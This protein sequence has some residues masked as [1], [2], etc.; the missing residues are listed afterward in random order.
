M[1]MKKIKTDIWIDSN[2]QGVNTLFV[3][4]F[5]D[6]DVD[7]TKREGHSNYYLLIIEI[8]DYNVMIS[9]LTMT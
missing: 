6:D 9:L 7:G 3:L 2:F 5:A 4:P 8:N 1:Q